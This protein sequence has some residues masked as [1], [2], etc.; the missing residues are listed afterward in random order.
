MQCIEKGTVILYFSRMKITL[1]LICSAL[2]LSVSPPKRPKVSKD[3]LGSWGMHIQFSLE[4]RNQPVP[5]RKTKDT[6]HVLYEFK[7]NGEVIRQNMAMYCNT[8]GSLY[9]FNEKTV[10]TG[11]WSRMSD[12]TLRVTFK[13]GEDE[14]SEICWL[15][16]TK[17][18]DLEFRMYPISNKTK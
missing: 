18:N 13:S 17:E 14:M 2:L 1:L 12:S 10:S 6:E 9:R 11:N 7:K 15:Y 5:Y 3:I 8:G 4:T 16:R